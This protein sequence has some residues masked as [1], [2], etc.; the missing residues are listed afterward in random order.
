MKIVS[1]L[2]IVLLATGLSFSQNLSIVSKDTIIMGVDSGLAGPANAVI[3]NISSAQLTLK[4]KQEA[5]FVVSG[6]LNYFCWVG[7][8]SPSVNE[9]PTGIITPPDSSRS[10][11][12]G[13]LN[14]ASG[15]LLNDTVR[16][17]VFDEN[18]TTDFVSWVVVYYFSPTGINHIASAPKNTLVNAFPDPSDNAATIQYS[19]AKDAR[20]AKINVMNMLGN[21]VGEYQLDTRDSKFVIPT[22]SLA[23]GIYFYSLEVDG[24]IISTKKLVVNR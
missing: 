15:S 7:C 1:L 16:Y 4:C 24:T 2:F 23:P 6:N 5:I 21:K 19:L 17:T 13:Y 11:F 9:S 12:H 18:D 10:D 3:K 20:T 8:Y 14:D 22:N